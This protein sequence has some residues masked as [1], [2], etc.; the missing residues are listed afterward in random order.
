MEY[1]YIKEIGNEESPENDEK[2]IVSSFQYNLNMNND[3]ETILIYVLNIYIT[4]LIIKNNI[5][6][7]NQLIN[8]VQLKCLILMN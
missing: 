7:K 8:I 5:F 6:V 4:R 2:G 3:Y 1:N